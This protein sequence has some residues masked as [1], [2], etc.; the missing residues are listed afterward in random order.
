MAQLEKNT[1]LY[2]R[3]VKKFGEQEDQIEKLRARTT[4]L[5]QQIAAAQQA[6]NEYIANLSVE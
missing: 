3:Y 4:E 6:I 2:A 1:E 5:M